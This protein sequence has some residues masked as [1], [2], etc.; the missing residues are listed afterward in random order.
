MDRQAIS[1]PRTGSHWDMGALVV[2]SSQ[3]LRI[4][5]GWTSPGQNGFLDQTGSDQ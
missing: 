3:F 2:V 5:A 1:V 4:W